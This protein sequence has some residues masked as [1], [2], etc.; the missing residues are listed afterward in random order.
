MP[1]KPKIYGENA[2][3]ILRDAYVN[4]K[5][6]TT[7][8]A[9]ESEKLFGVSVSAP[10]VYRE[11]IRHNI[12]VRGKS[13]SVQRAVSTLNIDE[14]YL[15]EA[16]I[17]WADGFLLG[18]G[19]INYNYTKPF[20]GARFT[21]SSSSKE[22]AEYAMQQFNNYNPS[23]PSFRK[24]DE[25]HPNVITVIR[26][27]SHPDIVAQAKR[28]YTGENR[29]KVVPQ[30]VRITP[31]SIMLWYLGDGSFT[32]VKKQNIGILRL[33]TCGFN[34]EDVTG[35]LIPK[36]EELGLRCKHEKSKNDI[37]ICAD[38]IRTFF[39]IIGHVS[40]VR[41]YDHKFDIPEWLKLLRLSHICPDKKERYRAQYYYKSGQLECSKSPGGEMLLF[42]EEQ[43]E[44]LK[45]KLS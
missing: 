29:K 20:M 27:H 12:Q 30:D 45:N 21:I 7:D 40:H 23:K 37:R 35:I 17:E 5:M 26:T 33:A 10:V 24:V 9:K 22:W 43:A 32:Y 36:L 38:S 13:E 19:G 34:V 8:I 41:C 25:K 18:D 6:S 4:C 14:T 28:W 39:N 16:V 11:L 44:K 42:T 15:T 2:V 3:N 1:V 31:T